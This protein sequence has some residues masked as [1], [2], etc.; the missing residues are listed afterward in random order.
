M[1][2]CPRTHFLIVYAD[3]ALL[4]RPVLKL[5]TSHE[6]IGTP[7]REETLKTYIAP[8]E[9]GTADVPV[10]KKLARLC[11][12]NAVHEPLSPIST[13]FSV[14]RTSSPLD[15]FGGRQRS[16]STSEYWRQDRLFDQLFNALV[17][18]L[19]P[20]KVGVYVTAEPGVNG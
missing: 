9:Q 2:Q 15:G 3:D 5:P 12:Q 19:D 7:D 16:P 14:P 18:F 11:M 1:M 20:R 13:A 10:L 8:L 4:A 17:N 6:D